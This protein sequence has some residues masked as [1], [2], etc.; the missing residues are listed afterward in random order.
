MGDP[1]LATALNLLSVRTERDIFTNSSSD[2][3]M[4]RFLIEDVSLGSCAEPD[5]GEM[6]PVS[7]PLVGEYRAWPVPLGR[8]LCRSAAAGIGLSVGAPGS[9]NSSGCHS[10]KHCVSRL[11]YSALNLLTAVNDESCE[12]Q[13]GK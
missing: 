6:G 4:S 3:G 1:V 2:N 10:P 7:I 12:T 13:P 5:A 8:I 9:D 11:R